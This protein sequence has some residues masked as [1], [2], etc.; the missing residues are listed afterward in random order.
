M[1]S[2]QRFLLLAAL[3]IQN[4]AITLSMRYSKG[5]L[6]EPY[7]VSTTVVVNESIKLVICILVLYRQLNYSARLLYNRILLCIRTSL[8]LSVPG[9]IY[10]IQNQ[11]AFIG[12][13]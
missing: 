2:V 8:L 4:A 6:H 1:N 7:L 5:V 10:M 12:L 13:Q 11:L 3:C 9:L